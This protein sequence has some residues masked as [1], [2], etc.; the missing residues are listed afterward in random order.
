MKRG[1]RKGSKFVKS[2]YV[3]IK[4]HDG[5]TILLK[6]IMDALGTTYPTVINCV[7]WLIDRDLIRRDG[8]KFSVVE[9][10]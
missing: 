6:D 4:R 5:Q 1:R 9:T 3:Y 7:R 10:S 2:V 8:K